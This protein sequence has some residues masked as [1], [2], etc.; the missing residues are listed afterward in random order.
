[1][2]SSLMYDILSILTSGLSVCTCYQY[3]KQQ[4]VLILQAMFSKKTL[5]SRVFEFKPFNVSQSIT[6]YKVQDLIFKLLYKNNRDVCFK[7]KGRKELLK[8]CSVQ[9]LIQCRNAL[10]N[11]LYKIYDP[12]S[13]VVIKKS[14]RKRWKKLNPGNENKVYIEALGVQ[15]TSNVI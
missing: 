14:T 5:P 1:M 15:R 9:Q 4:L 8:R 10:L 2:H 6:A 7:E 12:P 11:E 3:T 13:T